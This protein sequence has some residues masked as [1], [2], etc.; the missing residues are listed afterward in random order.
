[1]ICFTS[2]FVFLDYS[3]LLFVGTL[4]ITIQ[5]VL[6]F[7]VCTEKGCEREGNVVHVRQNVSTLFGLA[8]S[9]R[10]CYIFCCVFFCVVN[11]TLKKER[12]NEKKSYNVP[13]FFFNKNESNVILLFFSSSCSKSKIFF[14]SF[15]LRNHLKHYNDDKLFW[16]YINFTETI[17]LILRSPYGLIFLHEENLLKT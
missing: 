8:L 12:R 1:M 2:S 4:L 17:S 15:F 13:D 16:K 3:I 11:Y 14:E 6:L 9:W 7:F 10:A 5:N